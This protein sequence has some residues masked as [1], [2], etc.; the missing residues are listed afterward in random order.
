M[1]IDDF[2]EKPEFK[3]FDKFLTSE[4]YKKAG[5]ELFGKM[6]EVFENERDARGWFYSNIK[7][8]DD[9]RPYDYCLEGKHEYVESELGRIKHG[10]VS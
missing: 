1:N 10:I 8:L 5:R 2:L 6:L 3:E 4:M 9:K 7:S